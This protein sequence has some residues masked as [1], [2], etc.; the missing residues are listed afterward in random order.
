MLRPSVSACITLPSV[1]RDELIFFASSSRSPSTFVRRT[2]SEPA[3]STRW[4][5]PVRISPV[6]AMR[7]W[8]VMIE[9]RWERDEDEFIAVPAVTR[10]DE[11]SLSRESA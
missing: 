10:D 11:A 7:R 9:T 5:F 1:E 4:S 3:R 8:T 2:F 6:L